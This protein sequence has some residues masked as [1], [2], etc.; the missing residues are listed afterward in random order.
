MATPPCGADPVPDEHGRGALE[1]IEQQ[2]Q[3]G[4]A[5]VAGAQHVG[6]A[7]VAGADVA[8]VAEAG[9]ARQK[10]A[11]GDR[12]EQVAERRGASV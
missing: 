8:H 11:E 2:R 7:D 10:I 12:A 1:R 5:L 4:E 3:R 9:R 6:G